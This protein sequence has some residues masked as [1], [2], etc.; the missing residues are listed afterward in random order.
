MN[1]LHPQIHPHF[2]PLGRG[3]V[4]S[5]QSCR[6][7]F[8]SLAAGESMHSVYSN[9]SPNVKQRNHNNNNIIVTGQTGHNKKGKKKDAN[10]E[11]EEE[12]DTSTD[13]TPKAVQ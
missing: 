7:S 9:P 13:Q 1:V 3:S 6:S 8:N 10:N 5:L 2:S 12:E 4:V 11:G